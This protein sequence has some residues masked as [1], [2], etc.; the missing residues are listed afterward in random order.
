M[1]QRQLDILPART[2]VYSSPQL[3]LGLVN[4]VCMNSKA[5]SE[6]YIHSLPL[7]SF[8]QLYTGTG[9]ECEE[10]FDKCTSGSRPPKS[11][12]EGTP[13]DSTHDHY[14]GKQPT[15]CA[16]TLQRGVHHA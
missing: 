9:F 6:Q 16:L 12:H 5:H 15:T 4:R 13:L 10:L 14:Q 8:L 7:P 1:L 2:S 3:L 11:C